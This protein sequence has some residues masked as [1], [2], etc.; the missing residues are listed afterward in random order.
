MDELIEF[1][2]EE[3]KQQFKELCVKLNYMIDD[4]NDTDSYEYNGYQELA[5]DYGI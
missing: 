2:T 5:I 4:I 3:E 1:V